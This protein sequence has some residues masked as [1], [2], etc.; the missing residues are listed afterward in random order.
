MIFRFLFIAFLFVVIELYAF[1]A[2]KTLI[3]PKW[4]LLSYQL[5]SAALFLEEA[6]GRVVSETAVQHALGGS[7]IDVFR[8]FYK[9]AAVMH[10]AILDA[11]A[12]NA[13]VT[14]EPVAECLSR[15]FV[16][17]RAHAKERALEVL[18]NFSADILRRNGVGQ[19]VL[20]GPE[21]GAVRGKRVIP[22]HFFR[23]W[24]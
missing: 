2:F 14:I 13:A 11:K 7:F 3:K 22:G 1:Q 20:H 8:C 24:T 4:I 5:I 19:V 16:A 6:A 10:L 18:R 12:A 17:G 21:A 23:L 15:Q 9:T